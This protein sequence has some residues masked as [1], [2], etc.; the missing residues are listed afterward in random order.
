[1]E[2]PPKPRLTLRVG[3]VGHRPDKLGPAT[4]RIEGQ[5]E[6]VF[7]AIEKAAK[8]LLRAN[9]DCYAS[10]PPAIRLVSGFAEGADRLAV[11]ACPGD[12]EVE[13][14]LPFPKEVYMATF[15]RH[16]GSSPAGSFG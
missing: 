9:K 6:K 15:S 5:L 12:W 10:D 1:M 14:I 3:I 7:A 4:G 11:G 16:A 8:A 2:H 13:A